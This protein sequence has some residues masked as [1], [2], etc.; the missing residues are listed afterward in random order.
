MKKLALILLVIGIQVGFAQKVA[1]IESSKILDKMPEFEQATTELEA[2][3]NAWEAEL[4][5]KF[6]SI[7]AMYNDYVKSEAMLSD[8]L[9]LQKQEAIF[10]AERLANEYKESKFGQDGE[11]FELQDSK[12]KPSYDKINAATETIAKENGY[13]HVFDKSIESNWIYTNPE[14]DL[15]DK[16]IANLEL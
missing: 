1:F 14:H 8:D 13:D 10:E 5:S 15:T 12:L 7:E 16:V 9:K 6:E 2:Q 3:V 4:D 11:L